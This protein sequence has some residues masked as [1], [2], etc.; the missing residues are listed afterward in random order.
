MQ[1]DQISQYTRPFL[2]LEFK[3][4]QNLYY[5][6]RFFFKDQ[7]WL[8]GETKY[9][10]VCT[11][12]VGYTFVHFLYTGEYQTLEIN[13]EKPLESKKLCE[14]RIAVQVL[15]TLSYWRF[16]KLEEL[17]QSK[18]CYLCKS[19]HIYD[20]LRLVDEELE[21]E[22]LESIEDQEEWLEN[23]LMTCL[24]VAIENNSVDGADLSLV[25]NLRHTR[26]IKFF[27]TK[28]L[29]SHISQIQMNK[30]DNE[31]PKVEFQDTDSE[32][33]MTLTPNTSS[34]NES[35]RIV[36]ESNPFGPSC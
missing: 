31:K 22:P 15:L 35:D 17:V 1:V 28:F 13:D 20:I 4:R 6:P 10:F 34:S 27:A 11:E 2:T 9:D 7:V 32:S 24:N 29:E 12:Q 30:K 5:V 16:P 21:R 14:L 25:K 33:T 23:F 3:E 36:K 26:L 8:S 19:I 18:I